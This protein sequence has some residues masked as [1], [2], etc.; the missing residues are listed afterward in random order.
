M[1]GTSTPYVNCF[2]LA[3][4]GRH[5]TTVGDSKPLWGP[6]PAE[7]TEIGRRRDPDAD[8]DAVRAARSDK[9]VPPRTCAA[10]L[11]L[12][13]E[14]IAL[15]RGAALGAAGSRPG[16]LAVGTA[17]SAWMAWGP[18][19]SGL[20][21]AAVSLV[22]AGPGARFR[23]PSDDERCIQLSQ[24]TSTLSHVTARCRFSRSEA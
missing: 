23:G 18:S 3:C 13:L 17:K 9:G 11:F 16:S 5:L 19:R 20:N 15:R 10:A 24:S 6:S 8:P 22:D 7:Q 14:F 12:M 21:P 2:S 4:T 1:Y